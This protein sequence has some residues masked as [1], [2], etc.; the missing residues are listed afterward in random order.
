[1]ADLIQ[2]RF[3]V[4]EQVGSRFH[5]G[6]LGMQVGGPERSTENGRDGF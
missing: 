1:M 3:V 2:D 6:V 5:D 4:F